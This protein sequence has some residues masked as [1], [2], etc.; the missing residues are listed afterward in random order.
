LRVLGAIIVGRKGL[1]RELKAGQK[2]VTINVA[3]PYKAVM[4]TH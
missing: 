4:I 3:L 2:K 1:G